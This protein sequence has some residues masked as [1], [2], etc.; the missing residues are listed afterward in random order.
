[1]IKRVTWNVPSTASSQ[2]KKENYRNTTTTMHLIRHFSTF[3]PL[4]KNSSA[5]NAAQYA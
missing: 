3:H 1:M 5:R 2:R 4:W